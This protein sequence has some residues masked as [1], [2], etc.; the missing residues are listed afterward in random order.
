MDNVSRAEPGDPKRTR[1]SQACQN[2]RSLKARCIP[3]AQPGICQKCLTSSRTCEWKEQHP[4]A[5]RAR[6][7]GSSRIS[8]MEKKIDGLVAL[9][10]DPV[11]T[12]ETGLSSRIGESQVH[13]LDST[14]GIA[15]R[16]A[17][18]PCM[19]P[20]SATDDAFVALQDTISDRN[21]NEPM[22]DHDIMR[23]LLASGRADA[24][25]NEYRSMSDFFPFVPIS[26]LATVQDLNR[27]RPMLLL[28]ILTTAAW[29]DRPL[30]A[31][32]SEQFRLEL[33]H[34]TLV[35]P[36]KSLGII[37]GILVYLAWYHFHF[38]PL[39]QQLQFLLQ[40]AIGLLID[41][42]L[43]QKP[44]KPFIDISGHIENRNL[45]ASD[46]REAQRTLLGCYYL[47]SAFAN[48]LRIPNL[49]RYTTYMRDCGIRLAKDHEFYADSSLHTITALRRVE[50]QIYDTFLSNE[51]YDPNSSDTRFQMHA[52]LFES[53]M[54]NL[55]EQIT[56][57]A[58]RRG[59]DI[60]SSFINLV[61]HNAVPRA[62]SNT[63]TPTSFQIDSLLHCLDAGKSFL[64]K[65][66]A[67]PSSQYHLISFIEWM[68]LPYVI[69]I[70]SK[71]S[72]PG[73]NHPAA[74]NI[75]IAQERVR[76]DLYLESF[77]YRMQSVTTFHRETQ[78]QPDFWLS[79]VMIMEKTKSWYARKT[80]ATTTTATTTSSTAQEDSPL[81]ILR[82]PHDEGSGIPNRSSAGTTPS[83]SVMVG[84]PQTTVVPTVQQGGVG[85]S[86]AIE[87]DFCGALPSFD[88]L[89]D[90]LDGGLWGSGSFDPNMIGGDD[91]CF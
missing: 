35:R 31:V 78:P 85:S 40:I 29:R 6:T 45:S 19:A 9:L 88:N 30:Q 52:Q 21:H 91:L 87:D 50:D 22:I 12:A 4:R 66:L 42:G 82:N 86:T 17:S 27:E 41:M 18:S 84:P 79:M 72:F 77:C 56:I 5:K 13:S 49:F 46:E 90:L 26:L 47:S 64:D 43:H 53:Q 60:Q 81:E 62:T 75:K 3:S 10:V 32:L 71:L 38:D 23:D 28:A 48:G 74:W 15:T 14:P 65:F 11:A 2:C 55:E 63:N 89:E 25:L 44:K 61:L 16:A 8:Q 58:E 20:R 36:R 7:T 57:D 24:L 68:R 51:I 59:F 37:Q 34:R 67:I 70:L 73:V 33:A 39:S 83:A 80:Q 76:I 1:T 69:I 54:K